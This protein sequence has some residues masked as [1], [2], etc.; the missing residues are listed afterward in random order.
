ML[1]SKLKTTAVSGLVTEI[2]CLLLLQALFF[3]LTFILSACHPSKVV[4]SSGGL[5]S[6]PGCSAPHLEI[7]ALVKCQHSSSRGVT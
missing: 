2:I 6:S 7:F 4:L 3:L 5:F 1:A